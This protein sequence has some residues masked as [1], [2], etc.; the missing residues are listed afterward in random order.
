MKR[1]LFAVFVLILAVLTVTPAQAATS[2]LAE[3]LKGYFVLSVEDHGKI[4]FVDDTTGSRSHIA[5]ASVAWD[6]IKSQMIGISNADLNKLPEP[7][8][9]TK[10]VAMRDRL[11]GRF[12]LAVENH[13]EVWFV[14]PH[15]GYRHY[16]GTGEDTYN[17]VK[18]VA[19]GI[20]LNDLSSIT[21]S[22]E[23]SFDI[24]PAPTSKSAPVVSK[25]LA[26]FTD[27]DLAWEFASTLW[28]GYESFYRDHESY[29]EI[30]WLE[31]VFVFN[32]T[33]F[34]SEKGFTLDTENQVVY[35]TWSD[36]R[37]QFHAMYEQGIEFSVNKDTGIATLSVELPNEV[38]T[39]N[40]GNLQPGKYFFVSELG[41][42]NQSGYDNKES[43]IEGRNTSSFDLDAV[44]RSLSSV[45]FT[46]SQKL[47]DFSQSLWEGYLEYKNQAGHYIGIQWFENVFEYGLPTYL[48]TEGF[49]LDKPSTDK[50]IWTWSDYSTNFLKMYFDHFD[51]VIDTQGRPNMKLVLPTQIETDE[52]GVIQAGTYFYNEEFGL[53]TEDEFE[54][55]GDPYITKTIDEVDLG[56]ESIRIV[57]FMYEF[58]AGL[59]KYSEFV[60]GAYPEVQGA[61]PIPL[62]E[63]G[64]VFL[65]D[66]GIG[67]NRGNRFIMNLANGAPTT[68]FEYDSRQ[69]GDSYIVYFELLEGARVNQMDFTPGKYEMTP[70]LGI[71]KVVSLYKN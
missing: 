62:G 8:Q 22:S 54:E 65:S 71:K 56:E 7:G 38:N 9:A 30:K 33:M 35:W 2:N 70:E 41:L 29:P 69:G 18:G 49:T 28:S 14:N 16:L 36:L 60:S 50:I 37:E 32:Q 39:P 43:L 58:K 46:D 51:L 66:W 1:L 4:W 25:N 12:L 44:K 45:E 31:N 40:Y 42:L 15:T 5:D 13:G 59:L 61:Q 10:D 6:L 57:E 11:K 21:I 20:T 23:N 27:A 55:F 3:R 47:W 63:Q 24:K 34:L 52:E 48:T 26:D 19:L 68:H 17:Q 64:N 53:M 67:P